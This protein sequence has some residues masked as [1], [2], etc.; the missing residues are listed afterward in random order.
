LSTA[1]TIHSV[2]GNVDLIT[3]TEPAL[4]VGF[5]F[6]TMKIFLAAFKMMVA[7]DLGGFEYHVGWME[8]L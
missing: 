3:F 6:F 1:F 2:R 8:R 4:D 5:Q 7:V